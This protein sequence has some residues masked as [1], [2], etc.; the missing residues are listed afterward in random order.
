[1]QIIIDYYLQL[2]TPSPSYLNENSEEYHHNSSSNEKL[3]SREY[4]SRK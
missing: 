4:S 2:N 1:M 3:L